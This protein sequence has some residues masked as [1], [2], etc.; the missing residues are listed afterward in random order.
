MNHKQRKQYKHIKDAMKPIVGFDEA[1]KPLRPG[2]IQRLI[3]RL[4]SGKT[5]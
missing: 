2:D 3:E 5:I 1:G 4:K